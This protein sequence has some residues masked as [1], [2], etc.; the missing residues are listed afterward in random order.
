MLLPKWLTASGR[1]CSDIVAWAYI[2]LMESYTRME[3]DL[4]N[5]KWEIGL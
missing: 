2:D 4:T 5:G 1:G 3:K